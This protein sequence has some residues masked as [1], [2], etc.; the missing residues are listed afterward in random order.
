MKKSAAVAILLILAIALF[1]L[2]TKFYL[3]GQDKLTNYYNSENYPSLNHN[4][5][6]GGDAYNFIINGNYATGFFVLSMGCLIAGIVCICTCAVIAVRPSEETTPHDLPA[7]NADEENRTA[8]S[9]PDMV[10]NRCKCPNCGKENDAANKFCIECGTDLSLPSGNN[11]EEDKTPILETDDK[12]DVEQVK[13]QAEMSFVYSGTSSSVNPVIVLIDGK[14]VAKVPYHGKRTVSVFSGAHRLSF[15]DTSKNKLGKDMIMI[16]SDIK[17]A[18]Y[19]FSLMDGAIKCEQSDI[20][21]G[22]SEE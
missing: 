22:L 15:V 9:N 2:S 12:S 4:A 19:V 16:P 7:A 17:E 10:D 13:T 6:V 8:Q 3:D 14:A 20:P 5:Y 11:L 18:K 1:G 21:V